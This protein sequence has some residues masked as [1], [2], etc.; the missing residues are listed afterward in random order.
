MLLTA[1]AVA[2]QPST[3]QLAQAR[4]AALS[5]NALIQD[6]PVGSDSYG[7]GPIIKDLIKVLKSDDPFYTV[8]GM[9]TSLFGFLDSS[10]EKIMEQL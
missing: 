6:T 5:T 10:T 7:A 4:L 8:L 1:A 3:E 9:V 2:A